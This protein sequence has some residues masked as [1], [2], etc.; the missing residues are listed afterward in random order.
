LGLSFQFDRPWKQ[1]VVL[2]VEV[3]MFDAQG[4]QNARGL[5]LRG[6]CWPRDMCGM[7]VMVFDRFFRRPSGVLDVASRLVAL[8][9]VAVPGGIAPAMEPNTDACSLRV[10]FAESCLDPLQTRES[11]SP[12]K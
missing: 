4:P 3:L 5:S 10:L 7:R 9:G 12:P 8:R 1:D 2:Q 6:R 11:E